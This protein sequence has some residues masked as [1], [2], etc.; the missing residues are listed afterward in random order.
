MKSLAAAALLLFTAAPGLAQP[1]AQTPLPAPKN[2]AEL[3]ARMPS[4]GLWTRVE[5]R[6]DA[7]ALATALHKK[8]DLNH[9][10]Y[11]TLDEVKQVAKQATGATGE[12][13]PDGEAFVRRVLLQSDSDHDGRLSLAEEMTG[14][15]AAFAATDTNHDGK[16]TPNERCAAMNNRAQQMVQ[17]MKQ[18]TPTAS[19]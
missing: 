15:D 19:H 6:Q 9:D 12:L 4:D 13:P 7:D 2:C 1:P 16:V 8:L 17:E 3:L 11:V 18:A 5:T 14:T 10:G